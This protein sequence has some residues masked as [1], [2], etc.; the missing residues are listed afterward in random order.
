MKLLW[1]VSAVLAFAASPSAAAP[2]AFQASYTVSAKGLDMGVMKASL[3]YTGDTYTYQK[4]TEANGLAALLSGD[5]LTERSSGTKQAAHLLPQDYL[6]HHKNKR[7]DKKDEFRF[8]TPT[9]VA[10]AVDGNA[11]QLSV[12]AGTLDMAVLE[13][14]LMD[15][16]ATDQALNY[17]VVSK[18]KVQD[19][20]LRKLGKE[21]IEVPAGRYE[22]E[23]LEVLHN[24]KTRQTTLW[25]APA[26]NYALVQVRHQEDGE[27][28]ETRLK[29]YQ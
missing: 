19:Y 11:Y 20:R 23:K 27:V 25:L 9:Q 8:T 3:R 18:G 12:P 21:T 5:T 29:N 24:N 28:I 4:V 17:H 6:H 7:K 26:L 15:A 2:D 22:C 13:L 10:G 14:Y 16:L 1:I